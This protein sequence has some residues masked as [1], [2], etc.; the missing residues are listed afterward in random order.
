MIAIVFGLKDGAAVVVIEVD[1]FF[2]GCY[3][4][5]LAVQ[6]GLVFEVS[7][8]HVEAIDEKVAVLY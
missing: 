4:F 1:L 3:G 5:V 8:A 7:A 6:V 2:A